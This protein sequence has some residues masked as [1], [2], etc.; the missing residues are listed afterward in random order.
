MLSASGEHSFDNCESQV[1]P[2]SAWNYEFGRHI[3]MS[4][5]EHHL[6]VFAGVFARFSLIPAS[7]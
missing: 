5:D 3:S 1:A 6:A 2:W 4:A 7:F